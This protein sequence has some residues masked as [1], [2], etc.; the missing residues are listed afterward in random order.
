MQ[1]DLVMQ[2]TQAG[3]VSVTGKTTGRAAH[4]RREVRLRDPLPRRAP[5]G[6]HKLLVEKKGFEDYETTVELG[7]GIKTSIEV[8]MSARPS[9]GHAIA[10]GVVGW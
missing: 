4:R 3:W 2:Q 5:P 10:G 9:R 8:Q 7:Q 1:H 6:K